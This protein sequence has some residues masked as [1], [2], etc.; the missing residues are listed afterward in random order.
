M[1]P[2][3]SKLSETVCAASR[4]A[5]ALSKSTI[6]MGAKLALA[7]EMKRWNWVVDLCIA[8]SWFIGELS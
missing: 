3:E 4:G 5:A 6:T 8:G 2:S 7:S 1:L